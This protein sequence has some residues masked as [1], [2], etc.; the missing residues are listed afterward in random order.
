MNKQVNVQ[1]LP[2]CKVILSWRCGVWQAV[3]ESRLQKI[4]KFHNTVRKK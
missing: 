3:S 1:Y 2:M 4:N